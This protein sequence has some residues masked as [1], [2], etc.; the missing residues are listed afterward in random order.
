ME[1]FPSTLDVLRAGI[2]DAKYKGRKW[3][4]WEE[5]WDE[6]VGPLVAP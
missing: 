4:S 5:N 1:R 3:G 2:K 6:V